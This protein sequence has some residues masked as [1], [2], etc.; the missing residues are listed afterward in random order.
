V[1]TTALRGNARAIDPHHPKTRL[2][3]ISAAD[4]RSLEVPTPSRYR[5]RRGTA[6]ER[7]GLTGARVPRSF[8]N[9]S[10]R[11]RSCPA[12]ARSSAPPRVAP[13]ARTALREQAMPLQ[14]TD[15]P[16]QLREWGFPQATPAVARRKR[17][18]AKFAPPGGKP[19]LDSLADPRPARLARFLKRRIWIEISPFFISDGLPRP[20]EAP[21]FLV[22]NQEKG[23][24]YATDFSHFACIPCCFAVY[25]FA[26]EPA[27][28]LEATPGAGNRPGPLR[29]QPVGRKGGKRE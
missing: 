16:C 4:P 13:A 9:A 18:C 29:G 25:S 20:R 7:N 21:I 6:C 23:F 12:P 27:V 17:K 15:L 5:H 10:G 1:R 3:A 2:Y 24:L 8:A 28:W 19:S 22:R 14:L 26:S 11:S